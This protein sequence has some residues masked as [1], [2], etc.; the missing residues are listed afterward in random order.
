MKYNLYCDSKRDIDRML[1]TLNDLEKEKN[2]LQKTDRPIVIWGTTTAGK[3]TYELCINLNIAVSAFGD[4]NRQKQGQRLFGLEIFSIEVIKQKYPNAVIIISSFIYSSANSV[5][6]QLSAIGED[7]TFISRIWFE[8]YYEVS[9]IKRQIVDKETFLI[10]LN[11]IASDNNAEWRFEINHRTISE[12]RFM[13]N[14]HECK[15]LF[16]V[17]QRGYYI[18]Y[19]FLIIPTG[20]LTSEMTELFCRIQKFSNV[21]HMILVTDG[22]GAITEYVK[23]QLKKYFIYI[24]VS[25]GC[26]KDFLTY[27][28]REGHCYEIEEL[29]K[30]LFCVGSKS[31][32]RVITEKVVCEAVHSYVDI[33]KQDNC[34]WSDKKVYIVQLFNGLANQMLMCL[35]GKLLEMRSDR[36]VIFDD[37]ILSLDIMDKEENVS[38][39][40]K[41]MGKFNV[42]EMEI[43]VNETRK[44][45]GFYYHERAEVAEVFSTPIRL[46]SDYFDADTWHL[47]LEKVKSDFTSQYKQAFPLGQLLLNMGI[48]I[49]IMQ[50]SQMPANFLPVRNCF[51]YDTHILQFPYEE[52]SI[53]RFIVT[54]DRNTYY[55]GVWTM[56]RIKDWLFT[57]RKLVRETYTFHLEYNENN[58]NY[59]KK[60]KSTEAVVIHIRRGDFVFFGMTIDDHYFR[61][62]IKKIEEIN[63]NKEKHYFVFSDDIDWCRNNSDQLGLY[64]VRN[65]VTYITGNEGKNSYIDMYL[66]SLGKILVPSLDSTFS[67][68]ALLLSES[69][70]KCVDARRY[71]YYSR[72]GIDNGIEIVE[73]FP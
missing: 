26:G 66:M 32:D 60:I 54:N 13:V 5:L 43:I 50:D 53:T 46:L 16:D 4:N 19:L 40:S 52:D 14:D 22:I 63:T 27:L 64:D 48:D 72:I 30:E 33:E 20:R 2:L 25:L 38:R 61:A 69:I 68:M 3:L 31:R 37:T 24:K 41:W 71:E 42:E 17:L 65:R 10:T 55:M 21:G 70:E 6:Q 62:A 9:V 51:V 56:G 45:S 39:I 7:F 34:I 23:K 59:I 8:Y 57:N 47:Y 12:Y 35:F 36:S 44:R 15:D 49:T 73:V 1:K 11:D 67:Y 18:K 28:Q 29:S 58:S